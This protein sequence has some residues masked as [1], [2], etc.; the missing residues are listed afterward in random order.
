LLF[1]VDRRPNRPNSGQAI[2]EPI[3]VFAHVAVWQRATQH[4]EHM[5][6]RN[7]GIEYAD[8][9]RANRS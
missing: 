3:E 6:S 7:D 9:I 1:Q 5:L 2:E 4:L 8:E